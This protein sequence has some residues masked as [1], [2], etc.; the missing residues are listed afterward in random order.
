MERIRIHTPATSYRYVI[1]A[2][3]I[4]LSMVNYIDRGA[5]SYA[6]AEI[7]GEYG[8][9]RAGWGEMMGYFGYGYM[10]GALIGGAMSDRLG[11]RKLWIVAGTAWSFFAVMMVWAGDLG[12]A[13]FGGSA[14]TGFAIIRI[15]FGFSE[16]PAYTALNKTMS[17]WAPEKERG[18][19]VSLG[20]LSTPLGA[21]LTAPIAVGLLL[22]TGSWR[23]MYVVLGVIGLA[24]IIIFAKIYT[25]RPEENAKVSPSELEYISAGKD[26]ALPNSV[27]KTF[28]FGG[29]FK[30]R[31]LVCNAIGL[32]AFLYVNFM[33]LTWTPKYLQ[34]E[35]GFSLSSL[36]FVGMIPWSGA[37]ITI[38]LGGR[39][40]DLLYRKTGNLRLAR[41][42]IAVC[43]LFLATITFLLISQAS[44][45][46]VV[47]GLMTLANAFNALPNSIYWAIII[48]TAPHRTGTY[49][50]I[51]LFIANIATILS[52]T[53]A[54]IL[55]FNYGYSAMF[56]ATAIVTAV[57]VIS[58]SLINPAKDR[59]G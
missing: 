20:V 44:S 7:M 5:I 29:F 41:S 35:F 14:L 48:D 46:W 8:F 27:G 32:F 2:V 6:S 36:M 21:M 13:A 52:P 16:G 59:V 43:S 23:A 19:A 26:K 3:V 12:L 39:L 40:S 22:L 53:L 47:I 1:F 24:L 57:G 28:D 51:T 18:F 30:N 9:D 34:D 58:M 55:S 37:C 54:G 25:N 33:I 10:F 42:S 4:L 31:T 49:S 38:L 56:I 11:A 17:L 50:G 45:A 15:C